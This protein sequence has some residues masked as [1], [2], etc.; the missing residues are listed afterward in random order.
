MSLCSHTDTAEKHRNI[1]FGSSTDGEGSNEEFA[2]RNHD[3]LF[4]ANLSFEDDCV[5]QLYNPAV[6]SARLDL[7]LF[8]KETPLKHHFFGSA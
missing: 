3:V 4:I 1:C 7:Q 2:F 6:S 5:F 8:S